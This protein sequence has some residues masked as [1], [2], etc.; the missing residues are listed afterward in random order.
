MLLKKKQLNS[1]IT[2]SVSTVL[3]ILNGWGLYATADATKP[4]SLKKKF[5]NF[6]IMCVCV[7]VGMS[8]VSPSSNM[9]R[10]KHFG[11]LT[12]YDM[13]ATHL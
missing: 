8:D 3:H 7:C 11:S 5:I 1:H 10:H 12:I 6:S 9:S 13:G 2:R 4:V